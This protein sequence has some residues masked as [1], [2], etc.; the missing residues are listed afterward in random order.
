MSLDLQLLL[1][2]GQVLMLT[3]LVIKIWIEMKTKK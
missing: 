2:E 1:V 3:Y